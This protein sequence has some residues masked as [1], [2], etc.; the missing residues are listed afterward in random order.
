[1]RNQTTR[2]AALMG[3]VGLALAACGG[4]VTSTPATSAVASTPGR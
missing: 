2:L 3:G 1:M 4:N